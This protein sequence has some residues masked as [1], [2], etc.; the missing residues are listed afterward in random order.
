MDSSTTTLWTSLFPIAGYL[1]IFFITLFNRNHFILCKQCRSWSDA[2]GL[3]NLPITPFLGGEWGRGQTKVNYLL[4]IVVLKVINLH[5]INC[6]W[7]TNDVAQ[8]R[9]R[10]LQCAFRSTLFSQ[11]FPSQYI[12]EPKRRCIIVTCFIL[13]WRRRAAWT[14]HS[15]FAYGPDAPFLQWYGLQAKRMHELRIRIIWTA[16]KLIQI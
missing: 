3:H 13:Q 4:R 12:D 10:D 5:F 14:G 1:V 2:L 6:W 9:R 11:S 8:I 16:V 15:L 7:A